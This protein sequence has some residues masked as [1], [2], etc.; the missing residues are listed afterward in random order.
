M[1]D[2]D[3]WRLAQETATCL[4]ELATDASKRDPALYERMLEMAD[5]I[6]ESYRGVGAGES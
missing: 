6:E 2:V 3:A 5:E 1:T 4:R